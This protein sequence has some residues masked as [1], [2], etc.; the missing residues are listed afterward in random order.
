MKNINRIYL[1]VFLS[2]FFAACGDD[3]TDLPSAQ[4]TIDWTAA[5]D[6]S[7][8]SLINNYWNQDKYH[9]NNDNYGNIGKYD[10]WTEAHGLDVLVDAY[11]RTKK[12]VY[13]KAIYDFYEGVKAKNGGRFWNNYYDD[14][15]WHGMA[16]LRALEA[17]GD[18]RYEQ[19]AGDLWKWI[20]E[21]WD[22]YGG[23]GI[24]WNH[25]NNV[26]GMSKGVPSNGPA[27]IIAARRWQKYGNSEIV[28]G[29]NDSIWL[30]MI[31]SW[32]KTYCFEPQTGRV[33]ESKNDTKGDWT[34]NAGTFIGAALEYYKISGDKTYLNDAIKTADRAISTLVNTSNG[35]LSD[36]AE[37][38]DHDVDLFKGIFVRYFTLLILNHDLPETKRTRYVSFMKNSAEYLWNKGTRKSSAVLFGY[39]WWEAP[40]N[41]TASLRVQL[42]GSMM[43]EAMAL[44][45]EKGVL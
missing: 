28:N 36:W 16:H 42:S 3:P 25:E 11:E 31:Y 6:S 21:G 33:F 19:S 41:A 34:Y 40:D 45:K 22:D 29:K 20:L 44:L 15:G 39:H 43:M 38:P 13:K 17:T 1:L 32:M 23:G 12:E 7:S 35:V 4:N 30:D 9:F 5:A 2:V 14:M 37:Q 26:A 18:N 24:R 10:Y 27:A 8:M